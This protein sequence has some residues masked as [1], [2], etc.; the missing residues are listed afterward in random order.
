MKSSIVTGGSSKFLK[1]PLGPAWLET[2]SGRDDDQ[3]N[4]FAKSQPI[5]PK[6]KIY[7]LPT[8]SLFR[9]GKIEITLGDELT[10]NL[11][12]PSVITQPISEVEKNK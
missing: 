2:A 12:V 5:I 3:E 4:S 7:L 1:A 6:I 9:N 10:S 8:Y 11:S